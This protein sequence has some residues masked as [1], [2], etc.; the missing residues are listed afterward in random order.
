MHHH[1]PVAAI[2]RLSF[3]FVQGKGMSLFVAD[4]AILGKSVHRACDGMAPAPVGHP[5][6]VQRQGPKK[7]CI[8]ADG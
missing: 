4:A 3:Q 2:G 1:G 6:E 5:D 7:R 8:R